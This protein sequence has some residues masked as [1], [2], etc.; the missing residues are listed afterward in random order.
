MGDWGQRIIGHIKLTRPPAVIWL[1]FIP[2]VTFFVVITHHL[3]SYF[4]LL[5]ILGIMCFDMT[6]STVNDI[7]DFESDR[8]SIE[9]NRKHRPIVM[10]VISK[11]AASYRTISL[12]VVGCIIFVYLS[13]YSSP[14]IFL[15][16]L[17]LGLLGLQYSLPPLEMGARPMLSTIF[18]PF[19]WIIYYLALI[20]YIGLE[21]VESGLLFLG[22]VI[23]FMGLAEPLAK[24][25]RDVDNDKRGGKI[26]T[27][28]RF[29]VPRSAIASFTL[30]IMGSLMWIYS[31]YVISTNNYYILLILL[32]VF[33]LWNGY[34]L[35]LTRRLISSYQK[36]DGRS[37]HLGYILTFTVAN[38][39]TI[40]FFLANKL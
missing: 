19:L 6:S 1:D 9:P 37:M 12:F 33:V 40:A 26:T 13:F 5:F 14:L 31:L 11:K 10:G 4:Y 35:A 30:S 39:L 21:K 17:L 25:I 32:M 28:V 34:C 3:P 18:W 15:F 22:S 24:D 36:K 16:A 23:L 8:R 20:S 29:G 2:A 7:A 38:F 27:V